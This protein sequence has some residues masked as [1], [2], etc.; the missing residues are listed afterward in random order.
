MVGLT[1]RCGRLHDVLTVIPASNGLRDVLT[2][3]YSTQPYSRKRPVSRVV[4]KVELGCSVEGKYSLCRE[5]GR[6][7]LDGALG[8]SEEVAGSGEVGLMKR[9]TYGAGCII[10]LQE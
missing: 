3:D 1:E 5:F 8:D 9:L 2:W 6:L 4:C 10:R 7:C